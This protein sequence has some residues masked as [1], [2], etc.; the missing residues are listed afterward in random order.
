MRDL[1]IR[2]LLI[3][4]PV[5]PSCAKK[6]REDDNPWKYP[7]RLGET[8]GSVHRSLSHPTQTT[9]S[10]EE[11]PLSELTIWFDSDERVTKINYQREAGALYSASDSMVA[12]N[13]IPSD[14]PF[15]FEP[16]ADSTEIDFKRVLGEPIRE[17][18]EPAAPRQTFTELE[19]FLDR[20]ME[21][22]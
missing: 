9:E 3:I 5:L 12:A 10:L 22:G 18:L 13:W 1:A 20:D 8:R 17:Y 15:Y 7:I 6:S 11:Y 2:F 19:R 4:T 14:K 16:A 21:R